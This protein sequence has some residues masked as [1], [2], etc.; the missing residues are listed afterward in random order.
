MTNSKSLLVL[1]L[2]MFATL[3]LFSCSQDEDTQS[4]SNNKLE[5]EKS[6]KLMQLFES[7]GWELDTTASE[8]QRKQELQQMDFDKTKQFLEFMKGGWEMEP[9]DTMTSEHR[10]MIDGNTRSN[11]TFVINGK[12]NNGV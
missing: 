3:G 1:S 11:Q 10:S 5:Q 2:M 9:V 6:E 4:A 12:H 8:E 7:Y